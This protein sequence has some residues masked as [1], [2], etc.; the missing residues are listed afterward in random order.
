MAATGSAGH[1]GFGWSVPGMIAARTQRIRIGTGIIGSTVLCA[2]VIIGH[3]AATLSILSVGRF[4][5]VG[6]SDWLNERVVARSRRS[7]FVRHKM[8]HEA[9]EVSECCGVGALSHSLA[10]TCSFRT[11]RF[12]ICPT[13]YRR[14]WLRT[15]ER[16]WRL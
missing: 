13:V 15:V 5:A 2:P 6:S 12:L 3:A 14:F 4:L 9:L 11:P 10:S 1:G 7:A 8:L 16:L